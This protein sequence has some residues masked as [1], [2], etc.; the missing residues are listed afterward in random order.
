MIF[1]IDF[2]VIN[3]NNDIQIS[4]SRATKVN[5]RIVREPTDP[6]TGRTKDASGN[7]LVTL[8][9]D[10]NFLAKGDSNYFLLEGSIKVRYEWFEGDAFNSSHIET[11]K[12][13][14]GSHPEFQ[15]GTVTYGSDF[16]QGIAVLGNEGLDWKQSPVFYE[17]YCSKSSIEILENNTRI[18]C[19]MQHEA[20]WSFLKADV[21]PGES[22]VATKSGDKCYIVF[23]QTC[24]V[25]GTTIAKND[26]KKLTSDSVTITNNS[27]KLCRLIKI[28]K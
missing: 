23:G 9:P 10:Y 19:P 17:P 3:V 11:Y 8:H 1:S 27:S 14:S 12:E 20:G 6:N 4:I 13:V 2:S 18:L 21:V 24:D 22:I 5:Q 28:Y 25:N 26:V 15:R 16:I 7:D